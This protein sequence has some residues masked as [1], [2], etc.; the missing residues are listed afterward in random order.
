MFSLLSLAAVALAQFFL[1]LTNTI[2]KALPVLPMD[3]ATIGSVR[4]G[5]S[6][7]RLPIEATPVVPSHYQNLAMQTQYK[8]EL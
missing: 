7:Q 5:G 3:S 6:F 1:V 2:L 8:A 4:H